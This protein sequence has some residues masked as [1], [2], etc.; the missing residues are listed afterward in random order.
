[1]ITVD[2]QARTITGL[3]VPYW[4]VA[5]ARMGQWRYAPCSV[6]VRAARVPLLVEHVRSRQVGWAV[7][8]RETLDGLAA[9]FAVLRGPAGDRA[10]A[11]AADGTLRGL[12]PGVDLLRTVPS[13]G[14]RGVTLV[15]AA[16]LG[17]VSLTATP[18]FDVPLVGAR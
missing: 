13:P 7:D 10:L 5:V 3:A 12:S 15:L 9:V 6:R 11:Q 2:V 16:L 17:E 4:R 1:M 14:E 8:F 18:A